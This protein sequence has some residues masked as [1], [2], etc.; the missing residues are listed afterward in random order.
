MFKE[1]AYLSYPN[2]EPTKWYSDINKKPKVR[3]KDSGISMTMRSISPV[4][5]RSKK[6]Y[7]T[8]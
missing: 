3:K 1:Y 8:L 6:K 5:M 7:L 2:L 4:M